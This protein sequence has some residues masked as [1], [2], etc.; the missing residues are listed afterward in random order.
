MCAC[1]Y[2]CVDVHSKNV[3]TQRGQRCHVP[4]ERGLQTVVSGL[5]ECWE[6]NFDP[7]EEQC[8]LL[9]AISPVP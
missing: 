3:V 1:V 7:L 5:T 4:L 6:L 2:L 8:M 9:P